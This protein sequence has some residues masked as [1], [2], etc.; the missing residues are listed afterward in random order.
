MWRKACFLSA[1]FC[2]R[3]MSLSLAP[4][5]TELI[6]RGTTIRYWRQRRQKGG[7]QRRAACRLRWPVTSTARGR[8]AGWCPCVGRRRID[9]SSQHEHALVLTAP[10]YIVDLGPVCR[11]RAHLLP[12]LVSKTVSPNAHVVLPFAAGGKASAETSSRQCSR[13]WGGRRS[14]LRR[15]GGRT[16]SKRRR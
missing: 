15:G 5:I 6:L 12:A 4:K 2:S 10:E 9:S 7:E 11:A 13:T 3:N 8:V 16:P 14:R 1:L